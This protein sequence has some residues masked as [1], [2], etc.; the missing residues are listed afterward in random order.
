MQKKNT[1]TQLLIFT[2]IV[3]F[4]LSGCCMQPMN[5]D[6]DG[7]AYLENLT[8]PE[9][10]PTPVSSAPTTCETY[11]DGLHLNLSMN[12]QQFSTTGYTYQCSYDVAACDGNSLQFYIQLEDSSGDP[13]YTL[14][15]GIF[16]KNGTSVTQSTESIKSY[17]EYNYCYL[18]ISGEKG[19][20]CTW[21]FTN[22]ESDCEPT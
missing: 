16:V 12:V 19:Y 11:G 4:L 2:F 17:N 3:S 13:T 21:D 18:I 1:L 8:L 15:D 5:Y 10:T 20:K 9:S 7:N 14:S 6:G 22:S